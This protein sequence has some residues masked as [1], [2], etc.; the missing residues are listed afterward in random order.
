MQGWHC[1]IP[2]T[3]TIVLVEDLNLTL[4]LVESW[5]HNSSIQTYP[6][7]VYSIHTHV[8]QYN[9]FAAENSSCIFLFSK[10]F[11]TK[12]KF[13]PKINAQLFLKN[14]AFNFWF[15]I[16]FLSKLCK[17][18]ID[19]IL[20]I[21]IGYLPP[22]FF[23]AGRQTWICRGCDNQDNWEMCAVCAVSKTYPSPFIHSFFSRDKFVIQYVFH[24]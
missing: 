14:F 10:S 3:W 18:R 1:V 12:C 15:V 16:L 20:I 22:K 6:S 5:S 2:T 11:A 9:L 13:N 23:S 21:Y 17:I 8:E 7:T 4:S 19:V 24:Q